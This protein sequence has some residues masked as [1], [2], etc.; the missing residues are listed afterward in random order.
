MLVNCRF[1]ELETA[2]TV[3]N[4]IGYSVFVFGVAFLIVEENCSCTVGD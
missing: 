3:S 2:H 1:K 4:N